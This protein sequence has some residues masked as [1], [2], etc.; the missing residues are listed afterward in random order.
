MKQVKLTTAALAETQHLINTNS[1]LCIIEA[2]CVGYTNGKRD[3]SLDG[4]Y[5]KKELKV[6]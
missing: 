1:H 5:F 4:F 3:K 6:K 2:Y